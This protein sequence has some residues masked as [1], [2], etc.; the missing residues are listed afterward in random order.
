MTTRTRHGISNANLSTKFPK[1]AP[2]TIVRD[3]TPGTCERTH[4]ANRIPS[5]AEPEQRPR[6]RL[7]WHLRGDE[8]TSTIS[9][10]INIS[11]TSSTSSKLPS[12]ATDLLPGETSQVAAGTFDTLVPADRSNAA[13]KSS[14][15]NKTLELERIAH[16]GRVP[17]LPNDPAAPPDQ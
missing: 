1:L 13:R 6:V 7:L 17:C 2:K 5:Q 9:I 14:S 4:A 3:R 16:P 11:V 12:R 15:R 10:N 8:S